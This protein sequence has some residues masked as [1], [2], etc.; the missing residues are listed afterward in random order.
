[1]FPFAIADA[2]MT[3]LRIFFLYLDEMYKNVLH[4]FG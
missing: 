1:M 3:I 2:V 4:S